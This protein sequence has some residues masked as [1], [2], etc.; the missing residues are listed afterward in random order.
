M[1]KFL[2]LFIVFS[3]LAYFSEFKSQILVVN[4][5]D[6]SSLNYSTNDIKRITLNP[7]FI[8][9][10]LIDST[11]VSYNLDSLKLIFQSENASIDNVISIVNSM[12]LVI[13]PNPTQNELNFTFENGLIKEYDFKIMDSKGI[14]YFE[15]KKCISKIGLNTN[16]VNLENLSKGTYYFSFEEKNIK[17]TRSFIK[18]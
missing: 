6:N 2:Y 14:V 1:H 16:R 3:G 15:E 11:I 4:Q 7:I 18:L 8:N 12:D 13:F 9:I 5:S 10:Y 17:I